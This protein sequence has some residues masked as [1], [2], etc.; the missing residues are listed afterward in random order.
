MSVKE[1][2]SVQLKLR[3]LEYLNR[4]AMKYDLPDK[5]KALRCLIDY[6]IEKAD[7]E[8][9]IFGEIRCHEC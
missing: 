3:Q 1:E 5:S 9:D 6:A 2:I 7:R 8:H 4:M